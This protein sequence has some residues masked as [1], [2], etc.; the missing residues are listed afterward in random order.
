MPSPVRFAVVKKMLEKSGWTF[1][2][3]RGSHHIFTKPG[4]ASLPI[5]VHHGKVNPEYVK[6]AEKACEQ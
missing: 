5:P 2:R 3:V 1:E 4:K 6:K